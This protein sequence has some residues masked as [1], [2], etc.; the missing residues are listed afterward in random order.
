MAPSTQGGEQELHKGYLATH[1]AFLP[2]P[3]FK[4]E[5]G[6]NLSCNG[7]G[8]LQT[9]TTNIYTQ[10]LVLGVK[11]RDPVVLNPDKPLPSPVDLPGRHNKKGWRKRESDLF[12]YRF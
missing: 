11:A 7:K 2:F 6:I 4:K 5:R 12:K 8:K 9:Q 3:L 10:I 1:K